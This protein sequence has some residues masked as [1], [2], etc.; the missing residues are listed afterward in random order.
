MIDDQCARH[1]AEVDQMVPVAVVPGQTRRFECHTAPTV[2]E[3]TAAS[4]R[5]KPGR[6]TEPV[7]ERPG[8]HR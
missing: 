2:P 8:P 1:G 7:P 6:S 4:R 5:P 3:H